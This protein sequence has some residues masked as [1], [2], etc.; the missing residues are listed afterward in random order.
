MNDRFAIASR[1]EPR[2]RGAVLVLFALL[3]FV[4]F[5][6][7]AV[8]IDIGMAN[9][10]QQ[11]MQVATDSA[12]L[13]G[14]RW[15]NFD[16]GLGDSNAAKRQKAA[17]LVRLAFD[18][19]LNPTRGGYKPDNYAYGTGP[20]EPDDA[21]AAQI[22]AGPALRVS[23]GSG[24]W[25]ANA[26]LGQQPDTEVA[27]IDDPRLQS[28]NNNRP[29]GDQVSGWYKPA[30]QHSEA[31]DYTRRDFTPAAPGVP[32]ALS[33]SYLV[34]MR[35][36]GDGNPA[37]VQNN[38]SSSLPT[39]PVV[40]GLGS[41]I[42]QDPGN[43]WDPRRD[44]LTVRATSIACAR[45]AMRVGRP[46]CDE[47]N[48]L[49]FDHEP[50]V[51][52]T[53]YREHISGLVPFFIYRA[54]WTTHF[55]N[56]G[57]QASGGATEGRVRV[58]PDGSIVLDADGTLVGHFLFDAA[59]TPATPCEPEFGW[60]EVLGRAVPRSTTTPVRGFRFTTRK[61][62]YI[63]IVDSI[64]DA[65]GVNVLRVI[66]YGFAHLWPIG[67]TSDGSVPP[68]Q[69]N[70]SGTGPFVISP[71]ELITNGDAQCW[72]AQDNASAI[73]KS[74]A[75]ETAGLALDADTLSRVLKASNRLAYGVDEPDPDRIYDYTYIQRG[76][77]LAP[78]LTR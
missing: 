5:A 69:S 24:A 18:D 58:Q 34:R 39:L 12:A 59:S 52:G 66:G 71:G 37:D 29:N 26:V 68:P 1:T 22:A 77:V 76:T 15:R 7:A 13:E 30:Q 14:C 41:T 2:R 56:A 36:A 57:W 35:R 9:L 55:R 23:G 49:L 72:I 70:Y 6:I 3:T 33:L 8:V 28:N 44:G 65:N 48:V 45:P 4:F 73:L 67:F 40:F 61:P 21:D 32:N 60:P 25:A 16:E 43:D 54:A 10:T 51:G 78:A 75:N 42:L 19:D 74:A 11:Q 64:P 20:S 31:G 17:A 53:A 62:A 27:R 38:V 46:P 50:D 63:A 47:T